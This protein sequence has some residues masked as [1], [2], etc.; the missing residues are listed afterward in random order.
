MRLP[1]EVTGGELGYLSDQALLADAPDPVRNFRAR[2]RDAAAPAP[3]Y[4]GYPVRLRPHDPP[5]RNGQHP[6]GPPP[7]PAPTVTIFPHGAPAG[8]R[9]TLPSLTPCH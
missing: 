1:W 9:L 2:L 7:P 4:R 8:P 5:R 3:Q 6:E